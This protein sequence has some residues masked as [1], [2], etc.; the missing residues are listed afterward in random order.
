[1]DVTA[2]VVALAVSVAALI[3]V[4][5]T[6]LRWV[7]PRIRR[8][9]RQTTA[10]R[11]AILGREPIVD[12]ITGKEIEPAL[13]GLGVRMATT[14]QNVQ[15]IAEGLAKIAEAQVNQQHLEER[16]DRLEQDHDRR[17]K[18]LED[19]RLERVVARAESANAWRAIA[20]ANGDTDSGDDFDLDEPDR[21]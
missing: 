19:A 9:F 11:D 12:S 15:A 4:A 10:V 14:E 3:G 6:W 1:M 17:L 20:A 13:P 18:A 5:V 2:D 7:R 8:F 16:V 21:G